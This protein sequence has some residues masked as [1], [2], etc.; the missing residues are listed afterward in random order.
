MLQFQELLKKKSRKEEREDAGD[1]SVYGK[2]ATELQKALF[3]MHERMEDRTMT[4]GEK[5][6]RI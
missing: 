2:S 1:I 4:S 5:R 3:D 6:Y